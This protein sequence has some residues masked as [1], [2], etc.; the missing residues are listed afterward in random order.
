KSRPVF[1]GDV[2]MQGPTPQGEVVV[3]T[4]RGGC[5]KRTQTN[6]S[7]AQHRGGKGIQGAA[8]RGDDVVEQFFV[9]STHNW[10]LFFTN[11]G[12]VYRAKAYELPEG[13][14]D[15]KGQ[16]VANLLSLQPGV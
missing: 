6:L 11:T 2:S 14:R 7:R 9:T 4:T 15:A 16:H 12:R 3:T 1:D 5:A 13:T 10:L 8:L